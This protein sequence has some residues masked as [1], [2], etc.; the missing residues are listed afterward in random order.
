M[1]KKILTAVF[2]SA[3]V[4]LGVQSLFAQSSPGSGSSMPGSFAP[5][6]SFII[7]STSNLVKGATRMAIFFKTSTKIPPGQRKEVKR[8]G[9][10]SAFNY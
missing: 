3:S 8:K 10:K 5:L 4:G 1:K 7:S 2:L 9:V 6:S